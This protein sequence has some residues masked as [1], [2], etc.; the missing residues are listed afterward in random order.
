MESNDTTSNVNEINEKRQPK[1][2]VKAFEHKLGRIQDERKTKVKRIKRYHKRN[3]RV[4]E[5]L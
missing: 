2:T 5:K 4:D 1:L 3:N